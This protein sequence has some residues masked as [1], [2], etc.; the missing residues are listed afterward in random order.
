MPQN[1]SHAVMNQRSEPA[2]S[3]DHFPTPPWATR[4]LCE[5]GIDDLIFADDAVWEPACGGGHMLQ[6][7]RQ[8]FYHV[9]SSDIDSHGRNNALHD[10]I[11]DDPL[12]KKVTVV[13]PDWVITN[14]P[15]NKAEKFARRALSLGMNCALLVRTNFLETIGRYNNLYS[16]FPP[17]RIAQFAERV[18]MVKGRLDDEAST[19][20]SYCW[21]IWLVD[22]RGGSVDAYQGAIFKWIPPCRKDLER[23]GDYGDA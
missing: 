21:I 4:A 12:P 2:D 23:P 3:L 19:S 5:Y 17:Y 1:T 13:K 16:K 18:P 8:Y 10:F 7:L 11:G 15:F 14:P 22:H 20:T 6:P 9:V